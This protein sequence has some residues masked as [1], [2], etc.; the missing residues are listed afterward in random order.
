MAPQTNQIAHSLW[1][2]NPSIIAPQRTYLARIDCEGLFLRCILFT[3][4]ILCCLPLAAAQVPLRAARGNVMGVVVDPS[5][6]MIAGVVVHVSQH[7]EP[8]ITALDEKIPDTRTI[9]DVRSDA[10]GNFMLT[11][12][13]GVYDLVFVAP[14]FEPLGETVHIDRPESVA[15]LSVRLV[16]AVA[17]EEVA[18]NVDGSSNSADD[19]RSA[20]VLGA[21]EMAALSDDDATFQQQVLALAGSDPLSPSGVYVDGFSG[22][23]IPS[24]QSIREIR[25][26]QNPFSAQYPE[27]G[28]GR[29]QIF[30]KPGSGQWHGHFQLNY[31]NQSLNAVNPFPYPPVGQP[32]YSFLNSRVNV[33]GPINKKTSFSFESFYGNAQNQS[34]INALATDTSNAP[35]TAVVQSPTTNFAAFLR[36]DRQVTSTNVFTGYYQVRRVSQTNCGLAGC[37]NFSSNG[38]ETAAVS[39]Q[40]LP[41]EAF[42]LGST[43]QTLQLS[44]TQTIGKNKT[45]ETRFQWIRLRS[46]QTPLSTATTLNV[47]GYFNG[48]GSPA[49]RLDDHSDNTEFQEYFSMEHGK[50]FIRI[51]GRYRGMRDA[52]LN[53]AGFNGAYTYSSN[54]TGNVTALANYNALTPSQFTITTGTPSAAIYTAD[55]GIYADD[56]WRARP[57]LT[58][59][60]GFRVESQSAI[61]DRFNPA[62]RL[63]ASWA[64]GQTAKRAAFV[65]LR[66]GIGFFYDRFDIANLLT[67]VRQQSGTVEQS[68]IFTLSGTTPTQ[69]T[70]TPLPACPNSTAPQPTLYNVDP[71]LHVQY[72]IDEGLTAERN[73]GK[74]GKV[75][76]NYLH[77]HGNHDYVSRNINAPLPGTYVQG[78]A[79]SGVRPLGGTQNIYQFTSEGS[80]DTTQVF[81]NAQL[82]VNRRVSLW[83]F[84]VYRGRSG[85][86]EGATSFPT[87]QYRLQDDEGRDSAAQERIFGGGSFQLLWGIALNPFIG[88]SSR[89]PFNITTGIDRNGDTIYNDRP[90]FASAASP[91]NSVY[92]TPYG[93]FN[94]SPVAGETI[95]PVNYA[96]GPRFTYTELDIVKSVGF[97]R[98]PAARPVTASVEGRGAN[99]GSTT[100]A[101]TTA[102]ST[103]A[104]PTKAASTKTP[105]SPR[106]YTLSFNAEIDNVFNHTNPGPPVGVLTSPDFGKSL[107]L[108]STFIGSPNANR[109]VRL[110]LALNF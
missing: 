105:P 54:A 29:V 43:T 81:G 47:N 27:I 57:N 63:G 35:Y 91:A 45:L 89:A 108:N 110:G 42:D 18:V 24:K 109:M 46:L 23:Q 80:H 104:S 2:G 34:I 5:G 15:R 82:S 6:A 72:Q 41:S 94:A 106:P 58:L 36:L 30:T 26:N 78:I 107:S 79:A 92:K 100:P 83:A 69:C 75:S 56:E 49:Q 85:D 52:N 101:V 32:A 98:R 3:L 71:H 90:S 9:P 62:P 17:S 59:N 40:I 87:N 51:G 88:F 99:T 7:S 39:S 14:G 10:A 102:G 22:G 37:G 8:G 44:D 103:G 93:N 65:T 38:Q 21:P 16:I 97:G 74:I 70:T 86:V 60:F 61:P 20:L 4:F 1:D 55:L 31:N 33:S 13:P 84:A 73:I 64:V 53:T 77:L 50:H 19:N 68:Y 12:A 67:A 11:L 95:I 96:N 76:V 48:G 28:F 25:I 66:T